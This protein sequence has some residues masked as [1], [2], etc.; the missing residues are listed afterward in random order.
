MP[1][2]CILLTAF[3]AKFM[4][5]QRIVV[6]WNKCHLS[7]NSYLCHRVSTAMLIDW[8]LCKTG[9]KLKN[10]CEKIYILSG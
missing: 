6:S 4:P 1:L 5:N 10:N 2:V 8:K 9:I 3:E 7:S